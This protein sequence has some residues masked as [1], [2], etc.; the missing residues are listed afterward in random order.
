MNL[1][2]QR[3]IWAA[4]I[5]PAVIIA[6]YFGVPITDEILTDTLDKVVAL[7]P[8]GLALWSYVRPKP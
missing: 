1:L 2:L 7:A 4:L 6:G 5:P 8:S 3:R